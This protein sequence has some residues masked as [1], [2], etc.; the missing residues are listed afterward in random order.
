[1]MKQRD[2]FIP[3]TLKINSIILASLIAGIGA[4]TL[5][6][7]R[8]ISDAIE[9]GTRENLSLQSRI[10]YTSIENFMLPGEAPLAVEFFKGID[11]IT[12]GFSVD[13]Y[14]TDGEAAFSDNKTIQIV[15]R[16]IKRNRFPLRERTE[17]IFPE[18]AHPAGISAAMQNPPRDAF[19]RIDADGRIYSV[20]YK[21]LVNL[22]KCTGCHGSDHTIRGL[23]DIRTDITGSI[24]RQ[25]SA[26]VAA[27]FF[28]LCAVVLLALV[29][30]R[31]LHSAVLKPV[32]CIGDVCSGV[33]S[34]DF[35]NRVAVSSNDEIGRLGETVNSMVEGLHERFKLTKFVSSS[36]I[37]SLKDESETRKKRMTIF[38]SD[39]RGFTS[40]SEKRSPEEVVH[41]LNLILNMQ[42][43]VIHEEGGDVDKYVGDAVVALWSG[44]DAEFRACTA[45]AVIQDR[46]PANPTE[47]AGLGIGIGITGGEV[48]LGMI[49]SSRRAD[50]TVIG[51][52]VNTSS[53]LCGAAKRGQIIIS[54]EVFRTLPGSCKADGPFRL[55]VKGKDLYQKVYILRKVHRSS[56]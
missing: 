16:N 23:I 13:L 11:N 9:K 5:Y 10:I 3:I 27:G 2:R 42:T 33:A 12:E 17:G 40:F 36:T 38:F 26:L 21:P 50:F 43:E 52:T 35:S 24:R 30:G 32:K 53:R 47:F 55:K 1:M 20:I 37:E 14:R 48:I 4:I 22:P 41:Y 8:D 54:D 46:L 31:F 28:F 18:R 6:F 34:G 44:P 25:R 39:I 45:A 15:N 19:F 56:V 7:A 29:L 49:G 51:D